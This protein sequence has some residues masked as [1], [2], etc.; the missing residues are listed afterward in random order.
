M[1]GSAEVQ[2]RLPLY[3]PITAIL[4]LPKW[5]DVCT[6]YLHLHTFSTS[7]IVGLDSRSSP[8]GPV[9]RRCK[10][11][12]EVEATEVIS[13]DILVIHCGSNQELE[14]LLGDVRRQDTQRLC[15]NL[16][17]TSSLITASAYRHH[18]CKSLSFSKTDAANRRLELTS[19]WRPLPDLAWQI[20]PSRHKHRAVSLTRRSP[21]SKLEFVEEDCLLIFSSEALRVSLL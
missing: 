3:C 18:W 19:I 2:L 9:D 17:T 12:L 21:D 8:V 15:G 6:M 5:H 11:L 7:S 10:T 16:P 13:L 14:G 20:L 4:R 1:P